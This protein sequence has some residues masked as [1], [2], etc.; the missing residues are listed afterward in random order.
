[1]SRH[2]RRPGC[3]RRLRFELQTLNRKADHTMAA[4]D[5]LRAQVATAVSLING[6]V[7]KLAAVPPVAPP[8]PD[9]SAELADL[10]GQLKAATDA[11]APFLAQPQA[12]PVT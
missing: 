3:W 11:A 2:R 4:I 5:D 7:A 1:M 10:T 12:P 8:P 9:D 6:L